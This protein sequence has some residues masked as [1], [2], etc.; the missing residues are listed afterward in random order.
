MSREVFDEPELA[1]YVPNEGMPHRRRQLRVARVVILV[2][3]AALVVPGAIGTW[4][5][6]RSSA[7]RSC[8]DDDRMLGRAHA[9]VARFDLFGP[10]WYCTDAVHGTDLTGLGLI[11]YGGIGPGAATTTSNS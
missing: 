3:I 11:P 9:S 7:V 5:L 2:G 10:G 8:A 1:G 6:A 4:Q